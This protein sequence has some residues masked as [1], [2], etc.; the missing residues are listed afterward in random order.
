MLRSI[1]TLKYRMENA[2]RG[3]EEGAVMIEYA[4]VVGVISIVLILAFVTLGLTD[5]LKAIANGIGTALSGAADN[6]DP[7]PP[8]L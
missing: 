1:L 4:L 6:V 5:G 2:L 3:R 8:V 7:P